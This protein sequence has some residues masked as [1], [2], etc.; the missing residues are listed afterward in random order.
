M[1]IARPGDMMDFAGHFSYEGTVTMLEFKSAKIPGTGDLQSCWQWAIR[2]FSGSESYLL[3]AANRRLGVAGEQRPN[4]VRAVSD[5]DI[6]EVMT[7]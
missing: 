1:R 5:A 3:D 7:A 6:A 2:G 4:A